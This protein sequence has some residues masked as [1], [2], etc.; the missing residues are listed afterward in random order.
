MANVYGGKKGM[1][2]CDA[3]KKKVLSSVETSHVGGAGKAIS[4]NALSLNQWVKK[5]ILSS[6]RIR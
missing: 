2:M 4:R 5:S 6:F 1:R 3:K